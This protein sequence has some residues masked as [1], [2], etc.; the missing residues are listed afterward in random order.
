MLNKS[1]GQPVSPLLFHRPVES[2][3]PFSFEREK[4]KPKYAYAGGIL[5]CVEG[6][7]IPENKIEP[8]F[9][10]WM[11]ALGK[12]LEI[13]YCSSRQNGKDWAREHG[14]NYDFPVHH[15]QIATVDLSKEGDSIIWKPHYTFLKTFSTIDEC[16]EAYTETATNLINKTMKERIKRFKISQRNW[17]EDAMARTM[18][19]NYRPILI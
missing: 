1:K 13:C 17:K 8:V 18:N 9:H 10:D 19:Q 16:F 11:I 6:F 15:E 5:T 12:H 14:I 4:E 2:A 3:Q 7:E